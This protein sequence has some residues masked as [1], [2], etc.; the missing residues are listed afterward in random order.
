M[1]YEEGVFV[2]YRWY[3]ARNVEPRFCFGHGLSYTSF[4]LEPPAVSRSE[5]SA[6]ELGQPDLVDRRADERI[7][8]FHLVGIRRRRGESEPER[9]HAHFQRLAASAGRKVVR[10]V[11]ND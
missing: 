7:E 1:H 10:L 11:D 8:R 2:G 3:D 6:D 9:G 5:V 4:T